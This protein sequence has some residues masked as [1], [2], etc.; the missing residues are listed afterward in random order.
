[1][2]VIEVEGAFGRGRRR[3][4]CLREDDG[5]AHKGGEHEPRDM[6]PLQ[7]RSPRHSVLCPVISSCHR[8]LAQTIIDFINA[9][10]NDDSRFRALTLISIRAKTGATKAKL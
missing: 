1:M 10:K 9:S 4:N 7:K 3:Q 5:D 8:I 2:G 6:V